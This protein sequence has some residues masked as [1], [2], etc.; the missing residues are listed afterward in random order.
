MEGLPTLLEEETDEGS[1]SK[2]DPTKIRILP[3]RKRGRPKAIKD[4]EEGNTIHH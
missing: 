3:P 2:S 4:E 1:T